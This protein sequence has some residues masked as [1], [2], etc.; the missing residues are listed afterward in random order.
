M[1][2]R[3]SSEVH[4]DTLCRAAVLRKEEAFKQSDVEE[5]NEPMAPYYLQLQAYKFSEIDI[6]NKLYAIVVKPP[7]KVPIYILYGISRN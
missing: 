2:H 4:C 3:S 6:N 7:L 1:K 5:N